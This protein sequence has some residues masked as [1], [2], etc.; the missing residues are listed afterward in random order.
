M[1]RQLLLAVLMSIAIMISGIL[2][3][4][5][6]DISETTDS[7]TQIIAQNKK[8]PIESENQFE[9]TST[10]SSTVAK[11]QLR[12]TTRTMGLTEQCDLSDFLSSDLNV[13]DYSYISSNPKIVA[14]NASANKVMAV[15]TGVATVKIINT[16]GETVEFKITVKPAPTQLYLNK[17]TV[18]IGV[19]ET[20]DLNSSLKNGEGAYKIVYSRSNPSATDVTASGGYVTGKSV[21]IS[22][23]TA[24]TYN[25]KTATCKIIVKKA[26]TAVYLNKESITLGVGET[27]DLNSKLP[28]DQAAYKITYSSGNS[29]VAS[30]KSA[31]GLV[32][33]K[34]PGKAI[35]TA[36]TYNE[37]RVSCTVT[38]KEAPIKIS[39]NKT[40]VTLGIGETFDLNSKFYN[41]EIAYK[42]TYSSNK[43]GVATVKSAG[44]LVTAKAT[45]TA[46]ITAKTYNGKTVSCKITVKKAPTGISLNKTKLTMGVGETYDLNSKLPSGCG[47]YKVTY[48]SNKGYVAGVKSAGGV[49]TAKKTGTVVI[50]AETYNGKK[51]TC[52]ITVKDAPTYF[53]LSCYIVTLKVGKTYDLNALFYSDE[54]SHS[55]VYKSADSK[56][57][58]VKSAGGLVTAKSPGVTAIYATAF[59]GVY[60]GCNIVVI[61]NTNMTEDQQGKAVAKQIASAIPKDLSDLD[62]VTLA[63]EIVYLY[64]LDSHY[65]MEGSYYYRP[66]GVFI[67]GEYSC[68]GATR[69]LGAVLDYMG[70]DWSHINE[71]QYTHQ[72]CRVYMDGEWGWADPMTGMAGYGDYPY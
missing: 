45:G 65:T 27:F 72:W 63:S 23:I 48:S 15:G 32:T 14:I 64:C 50:T 71:N 70:Y 1:K 36:T 62:R 51:A 37:R 2:S 35:I 17:T 55:V 43:T 19:G 20:I 49:V 13:A 4:G 26:P 10:E 52:T 22:T 25:G 24:T 42:V 56:I 61:P 12:V 47:A 29:D 11:P 54:A 46:T 59:N 21:G 67:K 18:R 60:T 8:Q 30:V 6:T 68:A 44:G 40:S 7:I 3:V 53:E 34:S 69:A 57:A 5:A 31:G 28:E 9:E 16:I 66:Y 38:V 39:L 41:N 58:T 33:A